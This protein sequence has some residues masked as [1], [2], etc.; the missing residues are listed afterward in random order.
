MDAET[1]AAVRRLRESGLSYKLI[2]R[3]LGASQSAVFRAANPASVAATERRRRAY[4][5]RWESENYRGECYCGAS[6]HKRDRRRCARCERE[7]RQ[8]VA[9][10]VLD[11]VQ[12]MY[13]QGWPVSEMSAAFGHE[14]KGGVG[15]WLSALRRAGRVGYRNP[16]VRP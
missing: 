1:A 13:E 12:A 2:S 14:T 7:H 6:T 9:A 3:R 11:V 16:P 4:K 10:L 8:E 15:P 5:R